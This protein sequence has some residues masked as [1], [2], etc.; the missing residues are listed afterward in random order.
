MLLQLQLRLFHTSSLSLDI[1]FGIDGRCP[2]DDVCACISACINVFVCVY[3]PAVRV[4]VD[5]AQLVQYLPHHVHV[6]DAQRARDMA[7]GLLPNFVTR[8]CAVR[9]GSSNPR[10]AMDS[11]AR[12]ATKESYRV[13]LVLVLV[14]VEGAGNRNI[15]FGQYR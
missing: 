9:H 5:A 8:R 3:L 4:D 11:V 2:V 10:S 13:V 14:L 6:Q 15:G 7:R 1:H 12:T